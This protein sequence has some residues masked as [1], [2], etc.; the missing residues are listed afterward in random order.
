V[1]SGHKTAYTYLPR[2][3]ANFPETDVLAKA[4][5]AAGFREVRFE[6]LTFGIA[7]VHVGT[8]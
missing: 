1:I 7:A 3:V 4:M 8:K 5:T 2:S 6:T